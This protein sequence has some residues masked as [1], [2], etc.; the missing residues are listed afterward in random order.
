M[1]R[2][3]SAAGRP[4]GRRPMRPSFCKI[5]AVIAMSGLT[6]ANRYLFVLR[7]GR[8]NGPAIRVIHT[9]AAAEIALG[10]GVPALAAVFGLLD[11]RLTGQP[12]A[13]RRRRWARLRE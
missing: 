8:S 13:S 10:A 5:A 3:C 2:W 9:R 7:I 1:S 11:P 12:P 6:V 4:T